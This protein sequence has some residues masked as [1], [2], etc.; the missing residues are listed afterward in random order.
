MHIYFKEDGPCLQLMNMHVNIQ[1]SPVHLEQ[2]VDAFL[3]LC[4]VFCRLAR[5]SLLISSSRLFEM[6]RLGLGAP[7]VG[8]F[9]FGNSEQI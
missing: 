5:R 7:L 9:L 6:A 1:I 3:T 8:T 2:A 4:R